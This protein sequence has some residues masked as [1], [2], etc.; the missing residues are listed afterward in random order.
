MDVNRTGKTI[1]LAA[2]I[3]LAGVAVLPALAKTVKLP[4]GKKI[5][6]KIGRASCRE[7]V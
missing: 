1:A 4:E 5:H 3:L 7:R 2:A 6:F